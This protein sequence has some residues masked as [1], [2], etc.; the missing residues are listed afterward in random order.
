[1][2]N[3]M[4]AFSMILFLSCSMQIEKKEDLPQLQI[5]QNNRFLMTENGEPFFW[6]GDT[7]WLLFS[8]LNREEAEMYLNN[9]AEK[10]YNVIQA[11]VLHE[12]KVKNFYGDSALVNRDASQPKVTPGNSFKNETEYDFWDHMDYVIRLAEKKGIY[13]ALVPVWGSNV[14]AVKVSRQEADQY[15][16]WLSKRYAENS[17]II[18]L[19]GGDVKGSDST[20]TWN[21]MGNNIRQNAPNHLITFHPFGRTLSSWWFQNE[22]WLDFNSFQSGHRRYDQDDTELGYGQDN[23]KYVRDSYNLSPIKPTFDAEPSYEGIPQGLHDPSEPFWNDNDLRRYAYWSVF[24][25]GFGFTYGHSAVMQMHKP[26]D[27]K[28]SYGV[29]EYWTEAINAPGAGQMVHIKNLMLSKPYFERVPDQSLIA[30]GQGEKYDYQIATRGNNYALIY[31]CNG[32]EMQ[33]TM[34]KIAGEKV[35]ASWFNPR[36]GE[37]TE[38]G[39]F[40][41]SGIQAYDPPG[42]VRDGNDW[43]LV[44]DSVR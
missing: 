24:A 3:Y 16:T 31:T 15:S 27:T 25:G 43:V 44:L 21:I 42:E 38:I 37:Q 9:R 2:K 17:N 41:N 33:I 18:W 11:M 5:S 20:A 36:T 34:G 13:I 6:L 8:K 29:R 22:S 40:E 30:N 14:R 39:E 26:G 28:T 32:R 12:L 23:W 19:N 4:F 7:G 35:K 10:G 1:M